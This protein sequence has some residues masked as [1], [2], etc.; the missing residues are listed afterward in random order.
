MYWR[1]RTVL[2]N[3]RETPQKEISSSENFFFQKKKKTQ[4]NHQKV[5][6]S[7][8]TYCT[9]ILLRYAQYHSINR[10]K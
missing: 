10:A 5:V 8:K 2:I 7:N 1:A 6:S 3:M 4:P 9:Q